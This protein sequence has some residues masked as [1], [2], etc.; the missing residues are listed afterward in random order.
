MEEND[1]LE[2]FISEDGFDLCVLC[3]NAT[4]YKTDMPLDL[5]D[6]YVEGAGQ[7]CTSCYLDLEKEYEEH[8]IIKNYLN[9]LF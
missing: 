3:E 5:R 2:K 1:N 9:N 8:K 6:Y 7:L 4:E